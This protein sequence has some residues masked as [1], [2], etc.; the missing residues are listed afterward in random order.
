MRIAILPLGFVSGILIA[1]PVPCDLRTDPYLGE[2][3]LVLAAERGIVYQDP[4]PVKL[5]VTAHGIYW[6]QTGCFGCHDWSSERVPNSRTT[7]GHF[8]AKIHDGRLILTYGKNENA[9]L[10]TFKRKGK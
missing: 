9:L 7:L 1:A 4:S 2:W 3:E 6:E 8:D 5:T 10:Y